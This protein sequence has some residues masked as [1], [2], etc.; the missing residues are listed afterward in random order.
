M[1][2]SLFTDYAANNSKEVFAAVASSLQELGHSIVYN[3]HDADVYVIWSLLFYG[4]MTNNKTIYHNTNNIPVIVL[5]VGMLKRNVTWRVG[6][7]LP[8]KFLHRSELLGIQLKP[9]NTTG[10]NILICGQNIH[11]YLWRNMPPTIEEWLTDTIQEVRKYS[12][13]PIVFRP[14]PRDYTNKVPPNVT[15]QHPKKIP[16]TYDDYDFECALDDAWIVINPS[17]NTG[18]QAI[19]NGIPAI[20]TRD[21]MAYPVGTLMENIENPNRPDRTKWLEQ[22][23]NTEYTLEELKNPAIIE[24][25]LNQFYF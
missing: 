15:V 19:I 10:S 21:S 5:E 7:N 17:S 16:N 9:W 12:E 3:S 20:V 13:R 24:Y 4:K 2:F 23:C 14:H 6:S 11:S 22:V 25:I 18:S 8:A 1:I